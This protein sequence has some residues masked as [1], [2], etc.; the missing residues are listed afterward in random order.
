MKKLLLLGTILYSAGLTV[1]AQSWTAQTSGTS[2]ALS[3]V[4]F[5]SPTNGWAVGTGGTILTTTDGGT[6]WSAQ[7]SGVS[8]ALSDIH[9]VDGLTGYA[10]GLSG[11]VLK[12]TNGGTSWSGVPTG[13]PM[14]LTGVWVDASNVWVCGD[15]GG[16]A[17]SGNGGSTWNPYSP[18]VLN[19]SETEFVGLTGW[20][21]SSGGMIARTTNGGTS[22][23]SQTSGVF[24]NL[25]SM[26]FVSATEGW[27]SGDA[28]VIIHTTDGGMNWNTQTTGITTHIAAIH[29]ASNTHGWAI[30]GHDVLST[31]NGGTTWSIQTGVSSSNLLSIHFPSTTV[32]YAVGGN[33]EIYKYS[34]GS[35]GMDDQ[36]EGVEVTVFPNPTT[37]QLNINSSEVIETIYI[38]NAQGSL[39]QTETRNNFSVEPLPAGVYV[40]HIKTKN[41]TQTQRFIKE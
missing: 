4:Y 10:T 39:V 15:L 14:N 2:A 22:W 37:Q 36:T 13:A 23:T 9:F 6:N 30:S 38:Y 28:G 40:L 35:A 41:V 20:V 12:T 16:F 31:T 34:A 25:N 29:F 8:T 19:I 11:L 33:G 1:F 24:T 21:A 18:G 5:S 7:T 26:S 3:A 32:G 27:M 17:A